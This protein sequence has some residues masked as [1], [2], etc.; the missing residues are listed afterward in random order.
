[1]RGFWGIVALLWL[2]AAPAFAAPALWR[3][4]DA[5]TEVYIF[6]GV[7]LLRPEVAWLDDGLKARFATAERIYMEVSPEDRAP[8][9]LLPVLMRHAMLPPPETL[10][11]RLPADLRERSDAAMRQVGIDPAAMARFRPWAASTFLVQ[12]GLVELGYREGSGVEAVL[13]RMADGRAISGLERAEDGIAAFAALSRADEAVAMRETLDEM[14]NLERLMDDTVAAWLAGDLEALDA[15]VIASQ[16]HDL[17]E[18]RHALIVVRN[19][20]WADTIAGEVM[21]APGVAFVAVGAGHLVGADS[22]V[23]MLAARGVAV[24]RIR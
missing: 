23:R 7:H 15:A 24:E 20:A 11:D 21:A 5:D 2:T 9:A 8:G 16:F 19:R 12:A 18:L 1:M 4:H 3:A 13:G 6:G 14:P 22:L 10:A 17:P